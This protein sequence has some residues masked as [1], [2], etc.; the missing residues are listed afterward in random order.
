M[1]APIVLGLGALGGAAV[2]L[3]LEYLTS[4][5]KATRRDYFVAGAV[6]AVPG[7]YGFIQVPEPCRRVTRWQGSVVGAVRHSE[8]RK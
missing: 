7:G 8:V 3:G 1:P 6:G 4:G 5:G 2:S